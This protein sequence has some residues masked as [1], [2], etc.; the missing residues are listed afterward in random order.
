M[1]D[2][3]S[4]FGEGWFQAG[5]ALVITIKLIR[6]TYEALQRQNICILACH[7]SDMI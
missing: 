5:K 1:W 3:F 7:R 2:N 6:G 4:H